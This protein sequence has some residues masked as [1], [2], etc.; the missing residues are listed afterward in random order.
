VQANLISIDLV[1][2]GVIAIMLSTK[3][4]NMFSQ[5][6]RGEKVEKSSKK[7]EDTISCEEV[8]YVKDPEYALDNVVLK[9]DVKYKIRLF[10]DSSKKDSTG[11]PGASK[12]LRASKGMV[13]LFYGPPGTGKS[14]LAEAIA[15]MLGMKILTVEYPKI[16]SRWH[17]ETDKKISHAFKLAKKNNFLLLMDEADSLLYNR[18]Y[19]TQDHDIRFVNEMLQELDRFEGVAVLTTNMDDLLDSAVERRITLRVK[20]EEPNESMRAQIW[21][22]HVPPQIK[23]AEDVDFTVLARRYDFSGGYIRNAVQAAM[24]K[25]TLSNK[26]IISMDDL[27][28][29]AR[30]EMDGMIN[31]QKHGKIG[32]GAML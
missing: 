24:R 17:G 14:M 23:L 4:I 19:A 6:L 8:G 2:Q 15:S 32:F 3:A 30:I 22:A 28:F 13:F 25:I 1:T 18:S 29:G 7:E 31:K 10:I 16:L 26:D 21:K 9:D 11:Y 27:I 5:M 12:M 20:L